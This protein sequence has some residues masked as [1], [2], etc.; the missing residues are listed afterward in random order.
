MGRTIDPMTGK[1][2]YDI[3][4]AKQNVITSIDPLHRADRYYPF[5]TGSRSSGIYFH[6]K[7]EAYDHMRELACQDAGNDH[8]EIIWHDIE[9]SPEELP[10]SRPQFFWQGEYYDRPTTEEMEEWL[11][12]C[13]C[14]T[15]DGEWVEPD[16]P[17][18][19]L[20]LLGYI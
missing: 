3:T 6:T 2:V 17:D 16:H 5:L 20:S 14:E 4:V 11:S 7:M 12:D 8:P 1:P 9:W 15:P 13:G 10:E 18:S 19:W